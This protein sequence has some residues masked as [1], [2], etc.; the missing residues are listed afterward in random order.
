[1]ITHARPSSNCQKKY[2]EKVSKA[3]VHFPIE[4]NDEKKIVTADPRVRGSFVKRDYHLM[5]KNYRHKV[6]YLRNKLVFII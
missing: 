5:I 1:M 3:F 6:S 4:F 2:L